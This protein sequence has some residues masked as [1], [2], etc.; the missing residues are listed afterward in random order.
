MLQSRSTV[1]KWRHVPE[2]TYVAPFDGGRRGKCYVT[3]RNVMSFMK[4]N[5]MT[6]FTDGC[7]NQFTYIGRNRFMRARHLSSQGIFSASSP[8]LELSAGGCFLIFDHIFCS[9]S[10]AITLATLTAFRKST[11]RKPGTIFCNAKT[12]KKGKKAHVFQWKLNEPTVAKDICL[13]L[14]YIT[15]TG[16]RHAKL[17]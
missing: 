10:N 5:C 7:K 8:I 4:K 11:F 13:K 3:S 9:S 2:A 6:L 15:S 16:R 12:H 17:C 14:G 1:H